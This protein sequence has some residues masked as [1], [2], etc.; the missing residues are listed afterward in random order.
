MWEDKKKQKR[1]LESTHTIANP[2][3]ILNI[4]GGLVDGSE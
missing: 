3:A 1:D 2:H 4:Y